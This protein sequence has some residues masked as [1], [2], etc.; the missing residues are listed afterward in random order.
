MEKVDEI[1]RFLTVGYSYGD[2][3][4]SGY[5]YGSGSGDG[6]ES[7]LGYKVYYIDGVATIIDRVWGNSAKGCIIDADLTTTPCWIAK[8]GNDFAHGA[9][10]REAVAAAVEKY[11]ENRPLEEFIGEFV[12]SHPDLDEVYYDLFEWHH[13][14]TGSCKMGREK[15]C[16]EHDLLPTDGM[17]LRKF[18]TITQSA[19]G[20]DAIKQVAE[21]YN[22]N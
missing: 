17:V 18:L 21:R 15:W 1:E 19:Y 4:G 10:L 7:Y 13:T 8:Q 14:L 16:K 2:G 5:G 12:K 9:T 11:L 3:S 20:G 6:L 22:W